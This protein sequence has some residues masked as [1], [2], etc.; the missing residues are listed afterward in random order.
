[1]GVAVI[2]SRLGGIGRWAIGIPAVS[3]WALITLFLASLKL[4]PLL[5]LGHLAIYG[6]S[7]SDTT[8]AV[9]FLIW[10]IIVSV[11]DSF[12][13]PMLLGRGVDVPMLIILLGAIGGMMLSGI[14]GLFIGAVV[15]ALSYKIMG[16]LLVD[17]AFVEGENKL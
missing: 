5:I 9:I 14:L 13:K 10:S 6:F 16:A 8:P 3:L 15:L 17:N 4:P 2:Q 7:I 1:L 12:L 11:S